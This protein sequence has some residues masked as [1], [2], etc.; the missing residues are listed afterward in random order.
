MKVISNVKGEDQYVITEKGMRY[1]EAMPDKAK[2]KKI[3]EVGEN[4]Q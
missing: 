2:M 3:L 1:V 4:K